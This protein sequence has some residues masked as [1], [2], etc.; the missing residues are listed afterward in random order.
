M[1]LIRSATQMAAVSRRLHQQ[2]KRVGVV[3]TMGGLHE[4]HLSLIRR[5]SARNDVVIVTVF[6]NPLQ[7]GPRDDFA[8]YPRNLPRD[9]RLAARAGAHI[10]FAPTVA[11]LYPNGFST[12][13]DPGPLARRWEGGA[14]PGHF[15]GVATVVAILFEL[16][17]PTRAYFGQK[18]YQQARIVEQLA[19]DL[20][21]PVRLHV[22][23]TVREPDGL[24][25]S[26]RN[27]YL[28]A[29]QRTR[30]TAMFQVLREGA[31]RI[32][33]GERRASRLVGWMRRRL[34]RERGIRLDYLAVADAQT[35]EPSPR[36]RGRVVLLVAA[37]VGRT[38]LI[39]NLLVDVS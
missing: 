12:S 24:A 11:Q 30:A 31:A 39:D 4:G 5:A 19:H 26:S 10:T 3:P 25:L 33:A 14:R 16:T 20:R 35:L 9:L 15:R 28:S 13:L 2:G 32:R 36:I 29:R 8:R 38:R 23:P 6:V 21:W 22:L 17:R 37:R 18:D 1:R 7:F 27:A 34:R